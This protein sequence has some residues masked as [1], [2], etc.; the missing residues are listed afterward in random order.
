M[1]RFSY[2]SLNV[3]RIG[4][5]SRDF[6][7][8]FSKFKGASHLNVFNAYF[9]SPTSNKLNTSFLKNAALLNVS[10]LSGMLIPSDSLPSTLYLQSQNLLYPPNSIG[11]QLTNLNF[12][13][14]LGFLYTLTYSKELYKILILLSLGIVCK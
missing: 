5:Y 8:L 2:A 14:T 4:S 11:N 1:L 7:N 9:R 13:Q 6:V 3:L 10:S 12:A